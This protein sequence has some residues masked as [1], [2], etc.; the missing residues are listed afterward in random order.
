MASVPRSDAAHHRIVDTDAALAALCVQWTEL[1]ALGL[2]TEFERSR[3]YYPHPALLQVGD[4]H[5]AYLIDPL[6][7]T[8]LSPLRA[9]LGA[10]GVTKVL[11][12]CSEDAEVFRRLGAAAPRPLFDTQLAAAFAGYGYALG[13]ARL[14]EALLGAGLPK[15]E[16]RSDWLQRPLTESQ[17]NYA[18]LDVAYL[19][20]LYRILAARLTAAGRRSWLEEEVER[21]LTRSRLDSNPDTAYHHIAQAHLLGRRGL[22]VLRALAAWRERAARQRDRPRN[23]IVRDATLLAMAQ[24]PPTT[25]QGLHELDGLHPRELA[26]S[27]TAMLRA[28]HAGLALPD[29]ELPPPLPDPNELR[30]HAAL[31]RRLRQTVRERAHELGLPPELVAARRTIESLVRHVK[32]AGNTA[33]TPELGGWRRGVIGEPLL[34]L[35]LAADTQEDV[36]D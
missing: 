9:V 18:A 11:H 3:T 33:L 34:D 4:G 7:I 25:L 19:L 1:P 31:V 22:A 26:R 30:P 23:F 13:Y 6:A 17:R 12:G 32:L 2:D 10:P 21:A 20:P 27:G 14:V 8:D 35:L 28:I 29:A 24:H 5:T 16:T 15:D 36:A